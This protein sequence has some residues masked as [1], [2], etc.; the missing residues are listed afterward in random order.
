MGLIAACMIV[1]AMISSFHPIL[2]RPEDEIILRAGTNQIETNIYYSI[3]PL[4]EFNNANIVKQEYDYSCGSAA[5]ATIMNFYLGE[6][7][8]ENHVIQGLLA[9]G[10]KAQIQRR[11]AFSLLDMKRFVTALGYNVAGYTADIDDLRSLGMPCIVPIDIYD[12]KHFVVFR[13]IYKGHVFCADPYMGNISFSEDN[14][15]EIWYKNIIFLVTNSGNEIDELLLRDEDL[16]VV[17]FDMTRTA[18]EEFKPP[19]S[20]LLDQQRLLESSGKY[21]FM[22]R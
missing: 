22:H 21:F 4:S 18:I 9:Y 20:V 2:E 5:L 6:N 15:R 19:R 3:K 13:G 11:R 17:D 7:L 10:D 16:R 1:L 12:Y 8:T 14:F